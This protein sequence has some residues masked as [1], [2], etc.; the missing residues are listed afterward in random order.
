MMVITQTSPLP[1]S[2]ALISSVWPWAFS[3]GSHMRYVM[4]TIWYKHICADVHSFLSLQMLGRLLQNVL[5]VL[6]LHLLFLKWGR[7]KKSP[8]EKSYIQG[9]Y[10]SF[11]GLPWWIHC[12]SKTFLPKP[13]FKK[14]LSCRER[15][16][17]SITIEIRKSEKAP[18]L[19]PS[20]LFLSC[21]SGE[22]WSKML[23][24]KEIGDETVTKVE[25]CF[26]LRTVTC[27]PEQSKKK[28][29]KVKPES[30]EWL[31]FL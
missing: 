15:T 29:K 31:S 27:V 14:A 12:T 19:P 26:S 7:K 23:H 22:T 4:H 5:K 3:R 21:H 8:W 2:T 1:P 17:P 13:R 11:A 28:K 30:R 10:I 25:R 9:A 16:L 18:D 6:R 20:V 24:G